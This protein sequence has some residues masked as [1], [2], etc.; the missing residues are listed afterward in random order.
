MRGYDN[1][2]EKTR[3]ANPSPLLY[4][5][6]PLPESTTYTHLGIVQSDAG[7]YPFNPD[8]VKQVIRGTYFALSNVLSNTG[9]GYGYRTDKLTNVVFSKTSIVYFESINEYSHFE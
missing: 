9:D 1:E 3:A 6:T 4:G 8:D 7:R 5:N 2:Q